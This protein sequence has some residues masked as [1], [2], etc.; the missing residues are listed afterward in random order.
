VLTVIGGV[1]A[2]LSAGFIL[3]H[4]QQQTLEWLLLQMSDLPTPDSQTTVS[5]IS[6]LRA[7]IQDDEATLNDLLNSAEAILSYER[8]A[9]AVAVES[10]NSSGR[11]YDVDLLWEYAV[12][13]LLRPQ[14]EVLGLNVIVHPWRGTKTTLFESGGPD[15]DPDIF[16]SDVSRP[17]LVADAKNKIVTRP[18]AND[19]YQLVCYARRAGATRAALAYLTDGESWTESMGDDGLAITAIGVST[20]HLEV[21]AI[22]LGEHLVNTSSPV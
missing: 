8:E 6:A 21:E 13:G 17:V 3:S 7:R 9:W 1:A 10:S 20:E 4:H 15:L 11:F 19:V 5:A 18:L 22:A 14:A 12:A 2:T 16:V